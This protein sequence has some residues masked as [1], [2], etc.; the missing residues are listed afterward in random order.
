MRMLHFLK[1][2]W[3]FIQIHQYYTMALNPQATSTGMIV[4]SDDVDISALENP[5]P[6]TGGVSVAAAFGVGTL[7]CE[8]TSKLHYQVGR[9]GNLLIKPV[10]DNLILLLHTFPICPRLSILWT[11]VF[12]GLIH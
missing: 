12:N 5:T 3:K 1:D 8:D 2:W 6:D 4:L 7:F 9:D 10:E 11:V